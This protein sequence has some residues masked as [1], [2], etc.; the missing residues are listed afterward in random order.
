MKRFLILSI[1]SLM[2]CHPLYSQVGG[3]SGSKLSAYCVDVVDHHKLEFEPAFFHFKSDSYWDDE[4]NLQNL[5]IS[6]DSVR[7]VTGLGFRITYGLFDVLEI[8]AAISSDV[9]TSNWGLRY[10]LTDNPKY[11]FALM[12]GVNIPLGNK[13]IDKALNLS[14]TIPSAGGGVVFSAQFSDKL[15]LDFNGQYFSF[16]EKPADE[17]KG[18]L[19]YNLDVGYY[20]FSKTLQLIAGVSYQHSVFKDFETRVMTFFPGITI[21]T[22]EN[23]I[24]V[25]S[26][27]FDI[28]GK[29]TPKNS[30][31]ALAL[32]LTID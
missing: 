19:Y 22:G 30:G 24:L 28:Y 9:Q 3:I 7:W 2:L 6:G 10:V 27:L 16:L 26:A 32:T 29:N 1:I 15:S 14:S 23:Y 4:G 11:N 12:A 20:I 18:S 17:N 25:L 5:S 31:I 8:G 13:T 21:E